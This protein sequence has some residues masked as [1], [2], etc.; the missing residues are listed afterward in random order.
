MRQRGFALLT[1]LPYI[2][3]GLAVAGLLGWLAWQWSAF[4]EGLRE[5]GRA[6]VRVLWQ[7]EREELI[8]AR[9]AMIMRWAKA[10]QEVERVYITK[11][12]WRTRTFVEYRERAA[13]AE[14]S[15]TITLSPGAVSVLADSAGAANDPGPAAGGEG[16]AAPVPEPAGSVETDAREWVAFAVE[17]AEAY[18]D[19]Y[20]KWQACVSWA[21]E[22]AQSQAAAS[23]AQEG[24]GPQ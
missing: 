11:V 16:T 24:A 2:I 22:I 18:R 9:D 20:D 21:G 17:A 23:R 6:E 19:A 4:K 5:E 15:G 14:V 7:A 3:G 13:G 12:E 1:F 10:I 8:A